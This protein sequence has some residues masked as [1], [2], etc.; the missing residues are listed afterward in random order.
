MAARRSP[1]LLGRAD[2]RQV[3]DR[4]L[5]NVRG[6]QSAVLVVH[7]DAGVGK[8]ALLRHCGRQA[9][10]FRVARI[11]G[12][13]S[14]MEL[15]FAGLHQLC[16]R[17]LSRLGSLP[18]P[19]RVALGVA[20]GLTSGAT[21]D[22]FLV[23][24]AALSLLAEVAVERPLLCLVDD[25]QWVD[26]ASLQV[27]GFVSRRLLAES[28]AIVF[29]AREGTEE[30]ELA[31]LPDLA[32]G[33][34][35]DDDARA[36]LAT[37]IPGRLDE[38]VRDRLVSETRGNPL[39]ILEL[40]QGL[41][42]T[43]LPG[44]FGLPT[45]NALSGRIEES[46]LRRLDDLPQ[47]T[48]TLLLV[49]AAEPVGDPGL[50]WRAA[51]RLDIRATALE[52]AV[53]TG[54]LDVGAQ[55]RFR[56]PL[57]RSAVYRSA[58]DEARQS[59]HGALAE[60]TDA[61]LEPE[62][63]AWHQAQ[64]TSGPDE[65]VAAELERSAGRAQARGGLAAAAAFLGRAAD[66]TVDGSQRAERML[67]AAQLSLQAGAFDAALGWLAAA[68]GGPL[69]DLGRARVDLLYAQVAYAQSRGDDAPLLLQAAR[70]LEALDV[71]LSRDT[72]LDA[73]SAA[74][75][76]GQLASATGLRDVSQAA[77]T[78]PAPPHPPR[79]S[80]LLLD[81]FALVFT[82]GRPAAAPVLQ[83]AATA[84]AG[85]DVSVEEVLRWGWLA[86]AAA[87]F[88]WDFDTCL[89]VA[90]REV[91]VARDAGALEVLAVGVNV[92]G[93]AVSLSG[94][95]ERAGRLVA[96]A[97]AVT[98]ATGA[99]VAPYAALVRSAFRGQET[100]A[101]A[102]ID[103]TIEAATAGGQGT[104]VQYANWARAILMNGLGR[105]DEAL[106]AAVEASEDTPELFVS[107]WSLSEL[108]EAAGRT[109]N[110]E[111]ATWARGRLA[112]HT[113]GSES[114]WARGLDARSRALLAEGD[115]AE[116]L[117]REAID[118]LGRT[119][120]RPEIA[121]SQLLYGEWL[122]RANR[123]VDARDQL[124]PAYEAFVALGADAF[125]ERARHELQ[126]TGAKVRRRLDATRDELTP[127]EEHIARLARDGRTNPQ[128]GAEL[129]ISPRTVEWHLNKVFSK[130]GISSRRGLQ[131][132]LPSRDQEAAPV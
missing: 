128:I 76:A 22:R 57:V 101:T 106:A 55:V 6:G 54:L 39:A 108:I 27:L 15:P 93:Q 23:A 104:A 56:H 10:G 74:L 46:F 98:D 69:D 92:L 60:A 130:L 16:A 42:A 124:R 51:T 44:G 41:A 12:V 107:M 111:L 99:R 82:E 40:P 131:E 28:V 37:V 103:A 1:V 33:G 132:A 20:L 80:D 117:Y 87:A 95:F 123:R 127:Q 50:M 13:E 67:A 48:R 118:R 129:Y 66:L 102:L 24:L 114:G 14:E 36:L 35:A 121:R 90:T 25:V 47:A 29:A 63:R 77:M 97:D 2:E 78:A 88:V 112:E 9:S 79:P 75:F 45:A 49:A 58:S 100:E 109:G 68:Q 43:Q 115:D 11:G 122:R 72:Y 62:R 126:A 73:W 5:E 21:P 94:D 17:M 91:Q 85:P 64:A 59:A 110:T 116:P 81:G 86:T 84:F 3:L 18:E 26:A 125:A 34:L 30:R 113:D 89:E 8:T 7:G 83:R 53:R 70:T 38:R 4:L 31:G 96:E 120:L 65:D 119:R 19:Q 52:P 61:A 32:L 105:Y 71:R